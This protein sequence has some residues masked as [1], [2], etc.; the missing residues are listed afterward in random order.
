MMPWARR[1]G[2]RLASTT[3]R[4]SLRPTKD[5]PFARKQEAWR[6]VRRYPKRDL[7]RDLAPPWLK[8]APGQQKGG[9]RSQSLL[10]I[11]SSSPQHGAAVPGVDPEDYFS[12]SSRW[13]GGG[14]HIINN[15]QLRF[16]P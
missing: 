8:G 5:N 4:G 13:G 7:K 2:R 14:G 1:H 10:W 12:S 6:W 16:P 3:P 11:S 9:Q 15:L